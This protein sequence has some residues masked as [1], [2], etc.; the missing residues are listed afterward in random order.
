VIDG[1]NR[2]VGKKLG[3][4][5]SQGFLYAGSRI[6]AELDGAGAGVS[7]FVYATGGHSPDVMLRG[8]TTYRIL[9][10][11]LGSPRLVVNA[12]SGAIAQRLDYDEWGNTTETGT[13]GFQPFGFAGGLWDRDTNFVRFGARD[14]DPTTGR[15]TTKDASRFGGGLNFYAYGANDPV[16]FID[17]T[18]YGPIGA[19]IGGG[20]GAALGGAAGFA[21]G[22]GAGLAGVAGGPAVVVTVP[23]GAVVGATVGVLAGGG[24]GAFWGDKVGDAISGWLENRRKG[25]RNTAG[26]PT[27]TSNPD[28]HLKWDEKRQ[29]WYLKDPH[30]GK[31]KFKPPGYRPPPNGFFPFGPDD[32]DDDD[33]D[34]CE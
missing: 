16:N 1:L 19:A 26:K 18:G 32:D 27:G 15:W 30:T 3:G 8:G 31:P 22:G 6:I 10:D 33:N 13:V 24:A 28:K 11:H 17:P 21:L 2:R 23:A 14:Y 4:A 5:L 20:I 29:R 25:E 9:K 7:R 12:S 34:S